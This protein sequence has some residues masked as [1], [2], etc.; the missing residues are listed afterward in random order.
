MTMKRSDRQVIVPRPQGKKRRRVVPE[1]QELYPFQRKQI[2]KIYKRRRSIVGWDQGLGKSACSLICA[3]IWQPQKLIIVCPS[4]ALITWEV[5]LYQW[6]LPDT[7]AGGIK[8]QVITSGKMSLQN[9]TNVVLITYTLMT[10]PQWQKQLQG[11]VRGYR[12]MLTADEFHYAKSWRAKRTRALAKLSTKVEFFQGLTGTDFDKNVT[13]LHSLYSIIEPGR[14]GKFKDF[15]Y[16]YSFPF[17]GQHGLFFKGLRREQELHER[18]KHFYFRVEKEDVLHELP[19]KQYVDEY[20]SVPKALINRIAKYRVDTRA[21]MEGEAK[22]PEHLMKLLR[23][24][25]IAKVKA[26]CAW[27]D[28]FFL[29]SPE[30]PL[31]I[32]AVH[33]EV[34]EKIRDH[35]KSQGIPAAVVYGGISKKDRADAVN[36]FQAGKYQV[37]IG[38]YKALGISVTL[39]RASKVVLA[40]KNWSPAVEDQAVDRVHRIGQHGQVVIYSWLAAKT[41]DVDV[42]RVINQKRA[43]RKRLNDLRKEE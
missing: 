21:V 30:E 27:L 43:E 6:L 12:S 39:T 15:A 23:E 32:F 29:T 25:G 13:D 42:N 33:R 34:C 40:E 24:L 22:R 1:D 37:L 19:A 3:N 36:G 38:N 5:Q 8:P 41:L 7:F 4:V 28:N 14:W 35:L 10:R 16:R 20:I 9:D 17:E 11:F 26:G 2:R 18:S 31:V